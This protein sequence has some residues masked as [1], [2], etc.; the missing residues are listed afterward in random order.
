MGSTVERRE[1][2]AFGRIAGQW[3]DPDGP[4]APLHKLN[5]ARLTFIRDRV[6]DHCACPRGTTAPFEGLRILDVGCGGGIVTEPMARLGARVTGLDASSEVIGAA[7]AHAQAMGLKID[8]R[9]MTAEALAEAG[10]QFDVVLALEILEHV[11]DVDAF[12]AAL[13]A[14]TRPGGAVV[15]STLNRTAKAFAL[16]IVAA[17]YVL[18]W[19]DRGTHDWRKFIRPDDLAA[20]LT[21]AGF[22]HPEWR[23]LSYDPLGDRWRLSNDLSVNYMGIAAG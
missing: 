6:G 22:C 3:W 11:A 7:R 16:G 14:L 20:A 19:V 21:D 17:E 9:N 23:G 15:V 4:M 5:P 13:R 12:V 18:G 8:Y 2:E 1:V 10:E